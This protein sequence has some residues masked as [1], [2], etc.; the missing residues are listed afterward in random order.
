MK[1][2]RFG[3]QSQV[4]R[5]LEALISSSNNGTSECR[6]RRVVVKKLCVK[7]RLVVPSLVLI[8]LDVTRFLDSL[9]HDV[10]FNALLEAVYLHLQKDIVGPKRSKQDQ[11]GRNKNLMETCIWD[12]TVLKVILRCIN[13]VSSYT[14]GRLIQVH[15]DTVC[16][17]TLTDCCRGSVHPVLSGKPKSICFDPMAVT[18][19]VLIL[20][21][22]IHSLNL[23]ILK[24]LMRSIQWIYT[25]STPS[26]ARDIPPET[27][28]PIGYGVV[29]GFSEYFKLSSGMN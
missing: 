16:C 27:R 6:V 10:S 8:L 15:I 26:V 5:I 14:I 9:K 28:I 22:D 2:Y 11:A 21:M 17:Y 3:L 7:L 18:V 20:L 23:F 1:S 12:I 25:D 4:R 29:V 19:P 13:V 24:S